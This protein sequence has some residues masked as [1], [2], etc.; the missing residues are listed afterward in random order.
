MNE[1]DEQVCFLSNILCTLNTTDNN[2]RNKEYNN[3]IDSIQVFLKIHCKHEYV[4]DYIDIND[5]CGKNIYYCNKCYL[6]FNS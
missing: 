2:Y 5:S 3:I 6:N 1:L 4:N